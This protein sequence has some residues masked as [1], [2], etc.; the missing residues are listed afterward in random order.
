MQL[1]SGVLVEPIE[2]HGAVTFIAQDFD[3]SGPTFF[4]G[5]L[6]LTVSDPQE[7]HLEGLDKKIL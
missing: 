1:S 3:Q 2:V 7:M 4:G 6:Q 5:W